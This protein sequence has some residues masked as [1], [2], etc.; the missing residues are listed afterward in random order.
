VWG[1]KAERV[2]R[3]VMYLPINKGGWGLSNLPVR[4]DAFLLSNLRF[5]QEKDKQCNHFITAN[6]A[7]ALRVIAP[8]FYSNLHPH[9]TEHSSWYQAIIELARTFNKLSPGTSLL[10]TP[11]SVI[12]AILQNDSS[13]FPKAVRLNPSLDWL[14]IWKNVHASLAENKMIELGWKIIN[15]ALPTAATLKSWGVA[16]SATCPR[17]GCSAEETMTHIF[18]QCSVPATLWTWIEHIFFNTLGF[19]QA[20]REKTIVFLTFDETLPASIRE[21]AI[22]LVQLIK[23]HIWR[24]RCLALYEK[25]NTDFDTILQQIKG[26]VTM[27]LKCE[28]SMLSEQEFRKRWN[29]LALLT[30]DGFNVNWYH[31]S[32]QFLI[33]I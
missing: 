8:S 13:V 24:T 5:L 9:Y 23:L 10:N 7:G 19:S 33:I 6:C 21:V 11:L 32:P 16:K 14:N 15:N 17:E 20:C 22:Y 1:G 29:P 28:I 31:F 30:P 26:D 18:V 4:C 25:T 12:Y 2:K 3:E 27:R